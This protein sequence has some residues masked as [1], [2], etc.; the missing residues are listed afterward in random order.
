[1]PPVVKLPRFLDW[2]NAIDWQWWLGEV[3]VRV[4]WWPGAELFWY[5]YPCRLVVVLLAA[6]AVTTA[7]TFAAVCY[8]KLHGPIVV[9]PE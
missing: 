6:A 4:D 9:G 3:P 2:L 7:A 1:M 8:S 5:A